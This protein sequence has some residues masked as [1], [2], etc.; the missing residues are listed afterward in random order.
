MSILKNLTDAK[1][2]ETYVIK[3]VGDVGMELK[4]FIF[5]LGCFEGEEISLISVL[6][7][8]YIIHIKNS[9]YSIDSNLAKAIMI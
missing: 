4:E 3:G 7:D 6:S 1:V 8:N 9:R 2:G 5:T